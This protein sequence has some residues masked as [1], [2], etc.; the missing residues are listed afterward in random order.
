MTEGLR[1][2]Q[3]H[4]QDG[5]WANWEGLEGTG[6]WDAQREPAV[7]A[8]KPVPTGAQRYTEMSNINK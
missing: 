8:C 7:C 6:G 4:T 5:C 3:A 2:S 1:Q